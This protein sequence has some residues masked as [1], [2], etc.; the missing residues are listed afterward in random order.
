[1]F[2][3]VAAAINRIRANLLL[4]IAGKSA[5]SLVT[6][7]LMCLPLGI[8]SGMGF[9]G[10]GAIVRRNDL[11]QG[12]TSAAMLWFVIVMGLRF[13]AG[14]LGLG[15]AAMTLALFVL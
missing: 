13:G 12:V 8:L 6:L 10:A 3:A 9:I 14:Q 1:M 4:P 7:D 5:G 11:V 15:L 2:V